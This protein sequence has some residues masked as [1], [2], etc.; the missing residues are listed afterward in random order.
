MRVKETFFHRVK[1]IVGDGITTRFW[2]DTWLGDTPLALQC[3]SLY[4]IAQHKEDYVATVLQTV[5]LNIQFRRSLVGELWNSR[6][7]LVRRLMVVQLLDQGD[8]LN[9][10]LTGNGVFTVKSMYLELINSGSIPKSIHI[11]KLKVPLRIKFFMW[12][13][14][15]QVILTKDNLLKRR[16]VGSSCCCF[17]VHD[18]TIQHL[19]LDCP[20][21]KLL[22]RSVHIAFNITPP[23]SIDALF[24]MWLNGVLPHIASSIRIE[25]CTLLWAI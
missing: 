2:E 15:K 9:W 8:T 14:H 1:F 17:C 16:W 4:H 7:H 13:V 18:E 22:W 23:V 3:P 12:F 5:P 10:K 6:L 25:I 24:G 21:V 11:W 20:L 19:F